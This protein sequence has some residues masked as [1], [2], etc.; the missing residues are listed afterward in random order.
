M[1]I[2]DIENLRI[3]FPG[4]F[5]NKDLEISTD[6]VRIPVDEPNPIYFPKDERREFDEGLDPSEIIDRE[7]A[8]WDPSEDLPS[9]PFG[10]KDREI[11]GGHPGG[12]QEDS[13]DRSPEGTSTTNIDVLA[14]Y[15][16]FHLFR[17]W[18]GIYITP[19]GILRIRKEMQPFFHQHNIHPIEQVKLAKQLLYHHEYYHHAVESFATRLEAIQNYPCFLNGF[20][21]QYRKTVGTS[22]CLEEICANSYSREKL[23]KN[24]KALGV[25]RADFV[26]AI[27]DWFARQPA[28]YNEARLTN[29]SWPRKLRPQLYEDYVQSCSNS[30]GG[31][32]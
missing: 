9:V 22:D 19:E 18:W 15:L 32:G 1:A 3:D 7:L 29:G 17:D 8:R 10:P 14:F 23:L 28:G 30:G 5:K 26:S 21:P 16:P 12:L 27:N 20:I 25:P 11:F 6:Y 2:S 4:H 13:E 24:C 31:R